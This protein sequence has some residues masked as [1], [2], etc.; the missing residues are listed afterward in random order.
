MVFETYTTKKMKKETK[1]EMKK[2]CKATEFTFVLGMRLVFLRGYVGV[3]LQEFT[4]IGLKLIGLRCM[5]VTAKF[6]NAHYQRKGRKTYT[7]PARIL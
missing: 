2:C 1:K 4:N 6:V 7:G 3:I 5:N